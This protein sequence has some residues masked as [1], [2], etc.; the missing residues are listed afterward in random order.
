[1]PVSRRAALATAAATAALTG[2]PGRAFAATDYTPGSHPATTVLPEPDR[3]LVSRFSFGITAQLRD[4]VKAAGGGRAWLAAQLAQTATPELVGWWPDTEHDPQGIWA[5][6]QSGERPGW[7]TM[8][9]YSR[10]LLAR[11]ITTTKQ[12]LEVLTQF[13]EN[14]FHI[15]A[16]GEA[17]FPHRVDYGNTIRAHALGTFSDLLHAVATHPAMTIY[18]SG[19]AST[20]AHPN[21]NLGREL[22]ELHTVGVGNF[23]EDDVKS[24]ARIL[25]GFHI[26]LWTTFAPSYR[27]EDH[28]TGAVQVLG[29][30]SPNA[31]PDGRAVV[32]ALVDH[33]AHQ[34]LTARRIVR[35]LATCFVSDTPPESLVDHLTQVYL[36]HD[37]A[38]APVLLA[39]ADSAEFKAAADAKLRTPSEDLVATYRLLVTE[40]QPPLGD[41]SA[42]TAMLWQAGELGE[43]P[44]TWPRPDGA[45][46]TAEWWA[47]PARAIASLNV[48]WSL[49]GNWWPSHEIVYRTDWAPEL[50]IA[51]RDLVDHLARVL[52]HRPSDASVLQ[53]ACL[54]TG[55]SPDFQVTADSDVLG[56][57]RPRLLAALL[58][59]PRWYTR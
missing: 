8:Q 42:A 27:P 39:L 16:I 56:W 53:G 33:L 37:T 13:W 19:Y 45:P 26:D 57:K 6:S 24:A 59:H 43:M 1:M 40:L 7:K 23:T 38:I 5:G 2:L 25:T 32:A 41:D 21:E 44:M 4:A 54:A 30:A 48:H 28:W 20:K 12:V 35:K 50:P 49:A 46:L 18:L 15:P 3:H 17:Q 36:D 58:D 14:H 51:F 52:H 34:E 31:D 11:R 9:D 55:R 10:L 47:S 29:F 22:L